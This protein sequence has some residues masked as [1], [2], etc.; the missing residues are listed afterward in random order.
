MQSSYTSAR[1]LKNSAQML[2]WVCAMTPVH[3]RISAVQKGFVVVHLLGSIKSRHIESWG[4]WL[5]LFRLLDFVMVAEGDTGLWNTILFILWLNLFLSCMNFW[6]LG[7][8]G[9]EKERK[10]KW[11]LKLQVVINCALWSLG[12][13]RDKIYRRDGNRSNW[14]L[15]LFKTESCKVPWL[16]RANRLNSFAHENICMLKV[17]QN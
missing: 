3:L 2:C 8:G 9:E 16:Q 1:V 17:K 7:E 13:W 6:L 14:E 4:K 5:P 12:K 10:M 15:H 11:M